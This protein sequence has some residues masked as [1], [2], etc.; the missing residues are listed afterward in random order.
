MTDHT[1]RNREEQPV[2][3]L[4]EIFLRS[5][6]NLFDLQVSAARA[7]LRTQGR[8][9][10]LFGFPHWTALYGAES[11]HQISELVAAGTD[12]AVKFV[13]QTSD[14]LIQLQEAVNQHVAR[15]TGELA[16]ELR[17][18]NEEFGR[19]LERYAD[20]SR[21]AARQTNE[22][23]LHSGGFEGTRAKQPA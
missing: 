22:A 3:A 10:G 4:A 21:R 20:E 16:S 13:R 11:A 17:A 1:T 14:T 2:A 19:R 18:G 15:Q 12:Q 9:S 7:V 5:A 6:G 8:V 23:I